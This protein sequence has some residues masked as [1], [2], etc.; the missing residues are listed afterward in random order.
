MDNI[1]DA[2]WVYAFKTDGFGRICKAKARLVA[3]GFK[4]RE[5]IDFGETF[6]PTVSGS[7]VRLLASIACELD[8]DL[9]HFDVDQAFVQSDLKEDVFMRLPQGCGRLSGTVVRLNKSLYGLK[10]ASR[11][12]HAH[13]TE[14]LKSLGFEQC[15]ADVCVFRLIEEGQMIVT[16]VV[17]VDD[18]FAVGKQ[19][20][21]DQMCEDLNQMMPIKN[22]GEL[23]CYAGC[24]FLRDREHGL[25]T[26]SQKT[27]SDALVE[28]FGMISERRVPFGV[29]VKLDEFDEDEMTENWPFRELVGSLMWLATSTRPDISNAV[30]AVARYCSAP[31]A[32]HWRT[33]L[34]ILAYV[35]GTSGYGVTFQRGTVNGLALQVFADA[36]YGSKATD[37]RS[38]S[39]G[40]IMCGGACVSWF[41]RTQKC[42]T[43]STT[44]AEYVAMGEAVKELL[45]LRQVWHFMLPSLGTP[46]VTV[47]E[48]NQGALQLAQNPVTNSNSKH[49]DIRHHFLRELVSGGA[50]SVT[51]V[52]SAY[53]HADVLTKALGVEAFEFHRD[54]I[55]NMR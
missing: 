28:K 49:I 13:L 12:W 50:I 32:L 17:H 41:S 15:L 4:Q 40:L 36:D 24:Q 37:R 26:I 1:I 11:S 19:N 31:K 25:L 33:A 2:K 43:L 51:H 22:L 55:L 46:C 18:I 52:P 54:Y 42:V 3:R 16:A 48:D 20:R 23:R 35:K 34:G 53:Q 47:F 14:C 6:A 9:C 8:L 29:G 5:G 27:F 45:F 44:E 21:C 38:V 10:Q 39:G 30:R 7:C